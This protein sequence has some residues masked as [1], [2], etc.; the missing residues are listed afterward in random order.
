MQ[1]PYFIGEKQGC[2]DR[3]LK[4]NMFWNTLR[5]PKGEIKPI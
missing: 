4:A 1:N 3:F 5:L 2:K